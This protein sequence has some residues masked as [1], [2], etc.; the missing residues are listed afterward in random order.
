MTRVNHGLLTAAGIISEYQ[1]IIEGKHLEIVESLPTEDAI[2]KNKIYISMATDQ[3]GYVCT[4]R[5]QRGEIERY[6]IEDPIRPSEIQKAIITG[7]IPKKTFTSIQIMMASKGYHVF[8]RHIKS[9]FSSFQQRLI[10][11]Y[12]P[13]LS[14]DQSDVFSPNYPRL[15][16][17]VT[18]ILSMDERNYADKPNDILRT[19]IKHDWLPVDEELTKK[20][21]SLNEEYEYFDS[22]VEREA[23]VLFNR[24]V[25]SLHTMITLFERN[26]IEAEALAYDYA[27]KLMSITLNSRD[28]KTED[29]DVLFDRI[30]ADADNLLSTLD[31]KNKTT[32]PYH[33]LLIDL[34]LP[35]ASELTDV[36]GWRKLIKA[37]G[38]RVLPFFANAKAMEKAMLSRKQEK[39]AP[40]NL[41]EAK[42]MAALCTYPKARLDPKF[43]QLCKKYNVA[44]SRFNKCLQFIGSTWPKKQ[45]DR[46]PEADIRGKGAAEGY[47]WVKVNHADKR[48]LIMG[49]ITDCCQSIGGHGA[50]CAI[51]AAKSVDSGIYVLLRRRNKS[52]RPRVMDGF[53]NDKDYSIVGQAYAWRST[54]G[55]LCLDS[56]ECLN[57]VSSHVVR[58]IL[59][60]FAAQVIRQP[61]EIKRITVG[62]GGKT[63]RGIFKKA[64]IAEVMAEGAQYSDSRVQYLLA[65]EPLGWPAAQIKTLDKL[66]A[67]QTDEFK[68][69][70]H[71]L[72]PHV[73]V[74][75]DEFIEQLKQ[76]TPIFTQ[77]GYI[78][79]DSIQHLIAATNNPLL[80][81]LKPIDFMALTQL[82]EADKQRAIDEITDTQ[83]QL[84]IKT[85]DDLLC[86]LKNFS[87]ERKEGILSGLDILD[88]I[89][90]SHLIQQ[91]DDSILEQLV[92]RISPSTS[93][94]FFVLN[95]LASKCTTPSIQLQL[96]AKIGRFFVDFPEEFDEEFDEDSLAKLKK[97]YRYDIK[98]TSDS[99]R[100]VSGIKLLTQTEALSKFHAMTTVCDECS[101]Q[102][103]QGL[104]ALIKDSQPF[105]SDS[106]D[107]IM[108]YYTQ[109]KTSAALLQLAANEQLDYPQSEEEFNALVLVESMEKSVPLE[110]SQD[111]LLRYLDVIYPPY[112]EDARDKKL[113]L[114]YTM[115]CQNDNEPFQLMIIN[116]LHQAFDIAD[117]KSYELHNM[118]LINMAFIQGNKTLIAK[119]LDRHNQR[120]SLQQVHEINQSLENQG[121]GSLFNLIRNNSEAVDY[122][123]SL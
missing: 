97:N 14:G 72:A 9:P 64:D 76:L 85:L 3:S 100:R 6:P 7:K 51:Q 118:P 10:A 19:D 65:A 117:W 28:L 41:H 105:S 73:K 5:N 35:D 8:D 18:R 110:Q 21:Q 92:D 11:L 86:C 103:K 87:D 114:L 4:L 68:A 27:Y 106:F 37:E 83:F 91:V 112:Q 22:E 122:L 55:N 60:D 74:T 48:A 46:I 24:L 113:K 40:I 54:T 39:R 33:D 31:N 82:D 1:K 104:I 36:N 45:S 17:V 111:E 84:Q 44:E 98:S 71:Y 108:A 109:F 66:L 69:C 59:P 121:L 56:I 12:Q 42:E 63:P 20:Y 57:S 50:A 43:A 34:I 23:L 115:L 13:C 49:D 89:V 116:T 95:D 94:D 120:T 58:D 61:S 80:T 75:P 29:T 81:D 77:T 70:I 123:F 78:T 93:D 38:S 25:P 88:I 26:N 16:Q 30:A 101:M 2:E 90:N 32:Q 53:I 52:E 47:Y 62:Q 67:F 15:K 107:Q 79:F 96:Y 99:Y 119:F 102:L